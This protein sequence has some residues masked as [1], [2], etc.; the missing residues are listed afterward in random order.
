MIPLFY[1]NS[2][3]KIA[4]STE[5]HKTQNTSFSSQILVIKIL[6]YNFQM[7]FLIQQK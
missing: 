2:L 4:S 6:K 1:L 3:N 7:Y 5:K